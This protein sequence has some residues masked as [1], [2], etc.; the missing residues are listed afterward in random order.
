MIAI[1]YAL[2]YPKETEHLVL[3]S[4]GLEDW[5][6]RRSPISVDDWYARELKTNADAIRRY[7]QATYYA[8]HWSD[9]YEIWVQMWLA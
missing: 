9:E 5:S 3:G 7:E 2:M 8:G 4:I 1:R 6:Q